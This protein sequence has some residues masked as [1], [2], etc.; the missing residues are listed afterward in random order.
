[1]RRSFPISRLAAVAALAILLSTPAPVHAGDVPDAQPAP[2]AAFVD[3]PSPGP[4][5]PTRAL[6]IGLGGYIGGVALLHLGSTTLRFVSWQHRGET[7]TDQPYRGDRFGALAQYSGL[8]AISAASL[9]LNIAVWQQVATLPKGSR[10]AVAAAHA[11]L[12]LLEIPLGI[13]AVSL[14]LITDHEAPP[15]FTPLIMTVPLS[16]HLL[17]AHLVRRAHTRAAPVAASAHQPRA[18]VAA[19]PTGIA[20]R[21]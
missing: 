4:L 13:Y 3:L 21:W 14:S 15:V 18:T 1:M 11:G 9:T 6:K 7:R 2:P 17:S 20:V 12:M 8:F 10:A 16:L 19:G 5:L